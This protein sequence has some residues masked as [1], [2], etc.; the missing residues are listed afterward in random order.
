MKNQGKKWP[1]TGDLNRKFSTEEIKIAI[2]Y[3]QS[4][5]HH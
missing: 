5:H 3:P 4:A 2:R 1:S